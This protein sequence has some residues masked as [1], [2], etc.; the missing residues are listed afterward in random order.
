MVAALPVPLLTQEGPVLPSSKYIVT[1]LRS[2]VQLGASLFPLFTQQCQHTLHH[3]LTFTVSWLCLTSDGGST[4]CDTAEVDHTEE[5]PLLHRNPLGSHLCT[6]FNSYNLVQLLRRPPS[7]GHLHRSRASKRHQVPRPT[8]GR[9]SV[10]L[11]LILRRASLV[12]FTHTGCAT[13]LCHS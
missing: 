1:A 13:V 8:R 2:V 5:P 9:H 3:A 7:L 10:L 4:N 6:V 11:S 12:M